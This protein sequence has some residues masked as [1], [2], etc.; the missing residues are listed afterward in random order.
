M[1][2]L[3]DDLHSSLDQHFRNLSNL[4]ASSGLPLFAFEHSLS[5]LQID[6]MSSLLRTHLISGERLSKY[7]LLWVIYA[8]EI[9]YD[10]TGEEYWNS[11]EKRT[12]GWELHHRNSLRDWYRKFQATYLGVVPSGAWAENFPIIA[13]PITHAIL[14]KYLQYHFARAIYQNR[15]R[16][17]SLGALDPAT[18]GR[19]LAA[20]ADDTSMRF[21]QFLQQEEL[22]GRILLGLLGSSTGD[23]S[24]PINSPTLRRIVDDLNAVR[25]TRA[26]LK[27]VR[28]VVG[29]FK[30]IGQGSGVSNNRPENEARI[31]RMDD[32]SHIDIRPRIFLRHSGRGNWAVGVI[33][34][35][36]A[37]VATINSEVGSILRAARSKI[38]GSTDIKPAGWVLSPSRLAIMKS[39]PAPG[40]SLIQFE[41]SHPVLDGL[42]KTDFAMSAD[43]Y[44]L[45]RIGLDGIARELASRTVRPDTDYI[46]VTTGAVPSFNELATSCTIDCSGIS[47][48]RLSLPSIITADH[49]R[50]LA[51]AGIQIART[52]RIWPCG[53]PCRGWDGEGQSEWLTTEEPCLGIVHDHPV[54]SLLVRLNGVT[55]AVIT[56]PVPGVP[57]FIR[58]DRLPTGKHRLSVLAHRH[59]SI[60]D[61]TQKGVTEGFLDLFVRQP[62]PWVPG[63]SAHAGLIVR[64]NPHD[65]DL[66]DLWENKV[67]ISVVGPESHQVS[68]VLTLE[69]S[70]GEEI[71]SGQIVTNT[72]LPLTP[73]GWRKRLEA[74]I[75][76]TSWQFSEAS[77]G[78]VHIKGGELGEYVLQYHRNVQP[79]RL[80]T[81]R[82]GSRVLLK[83]ADDTGSSEPARCESFSMNSPTTK[84]ACDTLRMQEDGMDLEPPGGLYVA[85]NTNHS[86]AL[87]V[88]YG[89]TQG[90]LQGLGVKP[91]LDDIAKRKVSLSEALLAL[92]LWSSARLAGPFAEF[93]RK[94]VTCELT[95]AIFARICGE[96]WVIAE[97]NFLKNPKIGPTM[98]ALQH[99]V[100]SLGGFG[101]VIKRDYARFLSADAFDWYAA[102]SHRFAVCNDRVLCQFAIRLAFDPRRMLQIYGTRLDELNQQAAANQEVV[103]GAR[104][105]ALLCAEFA[106]SQLAQFEREHRWV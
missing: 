103:R 23:S 33:V 82:V 83:L 94:Q 1:P 25:A 21:R 46:L 52:I 101:A 10:Y 59:A 75:K 89:V 96:Q 30:G 38:A 35:N 56:E 72:P 87:I 68:C 78:R 9:G 61:I 48:C 69:R 2:L 26:W 24:G 57:A 22:T 49:I 4:R 92:D 17:A 42:L 45:F 58:L 77:V 3:L 76:T 36:L 81:Q 90:G 41:K 15:Y 55:K 6:E 95:K 39:W 104:F 62:E 29:K 32:F 86:D 91:N 74:F 79:V 71:I 53:L 88:S 105:G 106:P 66:E 97:H 27:D 14:P 73:E 11:F 31:G 99:K 43:S 37:S 93:R 65:A 54:S 13:W 44:W 85:R 50:L 70:N 7:W 40:E 16:L 47:G 64:S 34:P 8:A 51:K 12:P 102:L 19:L 20:N 5:T 28:T 18:M 100:C 98:E 80:L 60:A 63:V 67:D 84:I